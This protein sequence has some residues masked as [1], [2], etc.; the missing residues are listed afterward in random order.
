M[1]EVRV[2]APKARKMEVESGGIRTAMRPEPGG[3]WS[4]EAAGADYAFSVDGGT[5]FPDPR[6]QW[7][8][9]GVHGPSRLVDHAA[10]Q[11]SDQRWQAPPLASAIFYELHIGTFTPA[12]TFDAA[13]ARLDHLVSLGVTHVEVMPVNEFPGTR[14][15]GYDGVALFAPHHHYGGPD[16]LKRFVN[17][18]HERGLAAVLDVVYNHLGPSGNYLGQYGHYFTDRHKTPWGAAV[19]FDGPGSDES[20]RFFCDNVLDWF[21][22]YHFDALRI[23]AVH[24]IVDTSATHI[25]E[26]MAAETRQLEAELGRHFALIAESDLNDPRLIRPVEVGGYGLDAQW[27]DDFHHALHTVLTGEETGYYADFGTFADLA[28]AIER[29]FVYDGRHAPHRQRRHGRAPHGVPPDRFVVCLQNHDQVGNRARGDRTSHLVSTAR[30][31]IGA[32]LVLLA[33]NLPMLFQGEEWGA[34]SPFQYFTDHRDPGLGEAVSEG[35][36]REFAAFGWDPREVPD[37]QD[38]ETFRRS[39]LNWEEID[40]DPHRELLAWHRELIALRKSLPSLAPARVSFDE[41]VRWLSMERAPL[42][43]A[44]NL[45]ARRQKVPVP[46]QALKMASDPGVQVSGG[47]VDLP[48]DSVAVMV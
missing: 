3:W 19:N 4:G 40:R 12:G 29:A 15:W 23:D 32:A 27:S 36:R 20:R 26:Q 48:P 9:Y 24:A 18:C 47:A 17:A 2:W 14:G 16:G 7:Q 41:G 45:G 37:P 22:H 8:P 13:I 31:K 28:K 43:V 38:E 5:P 10:F 35:R 34:S 25:L 6:S 30:L 44:V 39:K 1:A 21:R 33:P 11:W 46:Q 42:T